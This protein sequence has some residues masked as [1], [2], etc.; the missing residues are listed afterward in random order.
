[1]CKVKYE[2][3]IEVMHTCPCLSKEC[4]WNTS[5]VTAKYERGMSKVWVTYEKSISK[6]DA[7]EE[8]EWNTSKET[9]KYEQGMSKVE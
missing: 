4:E 8:C 1:M 3:K 6:V 9:A 2:K 5:E 7:P